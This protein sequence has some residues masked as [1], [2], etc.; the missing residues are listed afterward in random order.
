MYLQ[1]TDAATALKS[2][3]FFARLNEA[4]IASL[5]SRLSVRRFTP[6][7][8]IFHLGDPGGLLY[9]ISEG[10]VRIS[11]SS[12]DGQEAF[13]AVLGDGDFFGEMALLDDAPRSA[14]AEALDPTVA[15]TLHHEEFVRFIQENSDFAM[16]ILQIM[17][18]LI[19][20][21]ND[22]VSDIFFLDLR[23]RLARKL[24]Q[25]ADRHGQPDDDGI[26]I[27]L[28]L[29]QTNLAEMTGATRVSINKVVRG[30][31]NNGWIAVRGRRYKVLDRDALEN[32]ILVSGG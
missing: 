17:S 25:L 13:L 26:L 19:R 11:R 7:Q 23:G 32:L 21:L 15:L 5:A 16:H 8:I 31:R 6:G 30:F 18:R 1:E 20:Q 3:P 4:D 29:T 2:I 22:Q 14:T 12:A 24:L 9:I 28:N 10:K 27:D